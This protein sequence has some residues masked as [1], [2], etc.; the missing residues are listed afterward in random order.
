[1]QTPRRR[2]RR[3]LTPVAVTSAL[4]LAAAMVPGAAFAVVVDETVPIADVQ[5]T[6]AASPLAGDTV[7]VEG[8]VTADLRG[9]DGYDGFYLQTAGSGGADD[10]TPGASDG[11]FVLLGGLV[12]D[13]TTGDHVAVT[14]VVAESFGLT[15]IDATGAGASVV[16][17]AGDAVA[18]TA[19]PLPDDVVGADR[20]ALEG[21]LVTPTGDYR[22]ASLHE[23]ASFGTVWLSAGDEPLVKNTEVAEPGSDTANGIAASNAARRILLDDGRDVRIG[24]ADQPYLGATDVVRTGDGVTFPAVPYVLGYGFDRWRLQPLTPLEADAPAQ[25]L[26]TFEPLNPRPAA[27]D[28][29]GGDLSIGAFNVLNYFTTLTTEDE[30]A[31]GARS[32]EQLAVQRSKIVTAIN[33]LGADVVALMEIENSIHF[34]DGTPDVALADL[35]AGLNAAAGAGT[36]DYVRTPAVLAGPDAVATTDVIMNAIIYRT[37]SVTPTGAST[38][39]VDETVWDNAR[40]PIAQAFTP[41]GGGEPFTV[42]ANH[43]KS[44]GGDGE[45][46]A[47]G[48]GLFNAD[49][50]AQAQAVVDLVTELQAAGPDD[51][52]VLGD[53]NSYSQ[54]DPIEA[55]TDAGF[56]DVVAQRAPGQYSYTFDGEL[57]SLDHALMTGSFADRVTGADIWNI[58]SPEWNGLEYFQPFTD[59]ASV[60]R[61]SDHDPLKI[62]LTAAAAADTVEIDLLAIN[63]FHGRIE[64]PAVDEGEP[65]EPSPAEVLDE[66]VREFRAQ[67]AN[68]VVVSAGDNIGASTF[69]SFVQQDNPTLDILNEIGLDA[70]AVGNHEFDQGFAD[71]AGRVTDRAEFPYLGANVYDRATGEPAL[72]EYALVETGGVT[73][74][75]IGAVTEDL[76]TLVT[77]AGIE[78]LEIRDVVTEVNRV[79][80]DL[81]D[82]DAANGEADV[83]VLL[84]HE[85]AE[86]DDIADLTPGSAFG[87]IATGTSPEV[88]A[89]VS[90]HTHQTYNHRLPVEGWPVG[91]TRP[92]V[93][94]GQYGEA[95]D[96]LTF[97]VDPV[98]DEIVAIDSDIVDLTAEAF[99]DS[100][101]ATV[102]P[103]EALVVAAAEAAEELGSQSLGE[104]TADFNR[105]RNAD[106]SENRGGESTLGNLVADVQLWATQRQGTQIA[107][108]NPGGL[109]SNLAYASS[110]AADEDGNVTFRE[111]ANVQP[112]ANTLVTF[113][114][115]GEQVVQVL[116][117][118]WQPVGASRPFL[119]LGV[120]EGLTYTYDPT[121]PAG[122]HITSVLLD[123]E[124][125]DLTGTYTVVA[126]SFLASGGDNFATLAEGDDPQDS[127]QID[128]QAFV[129]YMAEFSPVTPDLTQRSIGVEV[130]DPP[131]G[132]VWAPGDEVTINLSS[133]LFSAGEEQGDTLTYGIVGGE[134]RTVPIDATPVP[135]TDEVGRAT[136]A[137]QI[138]A[139]ADGVVEVLAE[140]EGTGTVVALALPVEDGQ[141]PDFADVTPGHPFYTDIRWMAERGLTLGT[142][143]GDERFFFPTAPLS[144]QAMAAFMYRYSGEVYTPEEGQQSFS[145]VGPDDQFYVAIEWMHANDLADGYADGTFRP[146]APVSRQAMA[147]FLHRAA[148]SPDAPAPEFP[149][150]SAHHQFAT[151]IGW[152][153]DTR[154]SRG[155]PDGTFR[156]TEPISRQAIAAFMHR[157]DDFLVRPATVED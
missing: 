59:P 32:P 135:T 64:R 66:A 119:K 70:S 35:V 36:W 90:A 98:S 147:A 150:V 110:G 115:T 51:V 151:A 53:L 105:A 20:E 129:E 63:D 72:D 142:Q 26:P 76:P 86:S 82:G 61:A 69:T 50:V 65:V 96:H 122:E 19:T 2:T 52:A 5:G 74:G 30:D 15:Q 24:A 97:H 95:L 101:P 92:V 29:V 137:V 54:E 6:G 106:G 43:F 113:E 132:G 145:D 79:A 23:V 94:A 123:G 116:E 108:M 91:L 37:A 4:A 88:D 9:E 75:F 11:V 118:Q 45:E 114:L 31:R 100:D 17:V 148:G 109:R 136:I 84:V 125:L 128:L 140:V 21:M 111:A 133:L 99:P 49:R 33:A 48:Q 28:A 12:T 67:N 85:G 42:V 60:Y 56:V 107:F 57:G 68:T 77:P 143:V 93:Q 104:I 7:T 121:A 47:D 46:P 89:I 112:F 44:K 78:T 18:P 102:S 73:M 117:E 146:T 154:I 1:M 155:Y 120:S 124:P 10:A 41:A 138:P 83:L 87:D 38:T 81:S 13:A 127:G 71:L 144:R 55:F 156:A 22:V 139:D 153:E 152:L 27:P 16:P 80:E 149:D 134:P 40:E 8:V 58:N 34:G 14:G 126:N 62:G 131:A 25:L 141:A 3:P 103:V 157:F 130:V 39:D